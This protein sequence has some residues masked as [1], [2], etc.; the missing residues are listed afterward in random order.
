MVKRY[1]CRDY[2]RLLATEALPMIEGLIIKA[3]LGKFLFYH[4]KSIKAYFKTQNVFIFLETKRKE[5]NRISSLDSERANIQLNQKFSLLIEFLFS[6]SLSV[7]FNFRDNWFFQRIANCC[8]LQQP[9]I[10]YHSYSQNINIWNG[11]LLKI[12]AS[13]LV[14]SKKAG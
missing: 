4:Y 2:K 10:S 6:K 14:C 12:L 9:P 7:C 5:V 13:M 8:A 11:S 3:D 1:P